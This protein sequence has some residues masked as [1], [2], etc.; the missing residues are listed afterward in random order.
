MGTP[1][2]RWTREDRGTQLSYP[3]GPGAL[4]SFMVNVAPDGRLERIENVMDPKVL[5]R[6][7]SGFTKDQVLRTAGPPVPAWEVYF[8]AR[9]EL[10]WEW[11]YCTGEAVSARF[12]VLLDADSGLVRSTFSTIEQCNEGAC[13]CR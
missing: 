5:A 8:P 6:I 4:Y 11:R 13:L 10:T 1:A 2:M 7:Q 12:H 3:R 9:R